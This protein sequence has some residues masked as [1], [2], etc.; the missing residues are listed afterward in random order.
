MVTCAHVCKF[1]RIKTLQEKVGEKINILT[2]KKQWCETCSFEPWDFLVCLP[3]YR[4]YHTR[5]LGLVY[6]QWHIHYKCKCHEN[7]S[8]DM[9][10][11][12]RG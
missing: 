12:E 3:D 1:N 8:V 6:Q 7:A 10:V 5:F 2:D 11:V 9:E 4:R